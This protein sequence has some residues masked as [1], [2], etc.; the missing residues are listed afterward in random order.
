MLF[1]EALDIASHR[2]DAWITGVVDRR[3][4]AIRSARPAGL[5]I[6][7]YGWVE[8][9]EPAG[10]AAPDG[11]F[12]HAPSI[13]HAA[14][15]GVLRSGY[16]SHNADASGDG[17]FAID[18]TSARVRTALH[19]V[20]GIRQGQPLGALLGY[21]IER[22]LHEA[23]L[24]RFILSLRAVAPLTQ[25]Q[26]SDRGET[27]APEALESIAAANVVDGIGLIE[28]FQSKVP[29][30]SA[31]SIRAK[32]IAPPADNPYLSGTWDPPTSTE[33]AEIRRIIEEAAAALDAVSDLLLA[34]SVHMLVSGNPARAAAALDAASGGDAPPPEPQFVS[35]PS[36]GALF[37]HRLL[38]IAGDGAGWNST[39]PRSAAEPRLEAWAAA[40]L[41]NPA[42]IAVANWRN[43]TLVTAAQTGLCAL[44]LVY[45]AENRQ[46][47][48][49]R[50]RAGL[51]VGATLH[52][53]PRPG[54]PP[55]M[56]AIGDVFECAASLRALLVKA[57][58]AT[59]HDLVLPNAAASGR[60]A[61][62]SSLPGKPA[63]RQ[64][65]IFSIC[66]AR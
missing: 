29:G 32:L 12:V 63:R 15:A 60:S 1:A 17:A 34:E 42:F 51:P 52:D 16:L 47:F 56:R 4:R 59:P 9:I 61:P 66:A 43:G 30:W 54:W 58:P 2:L 14:T 40:R 37:T 13:A 6:G 45:E 44:D 5:T 53:A 39:R 20:D 8:E 23:Q 46:A 10:D 65:A 49:H 64:R 25:G 26:L 7:A 62:P 57:R 41:G 28:K 55:G 19:L 38:A 50:L 11:G 33:W 31:N 48:E 27:L 35:T 24:D 22:G 21:R 3:L 18:L 36:E